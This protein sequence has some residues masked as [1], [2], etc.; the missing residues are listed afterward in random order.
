VSI[1]TPNGVEVVEEALAEK[2]EVAEEK[3]TQ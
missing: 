3:E 2:R 1:D